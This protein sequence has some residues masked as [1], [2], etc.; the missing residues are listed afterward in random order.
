VKLL[1]S[2]KRVDASANNNYAI[3]WASANGYLEIVK[4]LLSDK[5]VR[6]SLDRINLKKY[7]RQISTL[8]EGFSDYLKPKSEEEI[9]LQLNKLSPQ[10]KL[11]VGLR[12]QSIEIIKEALDEGADPTQLTDTPAW[13]VRA[14]E[15]ILFAA[16]NGHLETIK[17]LIENQIKYN[18]KYSLRQ[19]AHAMLWANEDGHKDV[20]DYLRNYINSNG[21]YALEGIDKF[22]ESFS[23][24]LKPKSKEEIDSISKNL[25]TPNKFIQG[26]ENDIVSLVEQALEEGI[27]DTTDN[28]YEFGIRKSFMYDSHNVFKFFFSMTNELKK[29]AFEDIE[30]YIR[31]KILIETNKI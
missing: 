31:H 29:L 24:Y 14:I 26:I 2:D 8:K 30:T 22:N 11:E 10:K 3:R 1:L 23:N 19:L 9:R 27:K 5:R 6:D 7:Q 16:F 28:W 18:Y 21:G 15:P 17:F 4:L 13:G 12:N 20:Q 25:S